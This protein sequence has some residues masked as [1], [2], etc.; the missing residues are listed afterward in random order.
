MQLSKKTNC[1]VFVEY[2]QHIRK[3]KRKQ[4]ILNKDL[5]NFWTAHCR[6]PA[7]TTRSQ[8][9]RS[10]VAQEHPDGEWGCECGC[11]FHTWNMY[12]IWDP[13]VERTWAT[14]GGNGL[15]PIQY[16]FPNSTEKFWLLR[17]RGFTVQS[18]NCFR[19]NVEAAPSQRRK[20]PITISM[21]LGIPAVRSSNQGPAAWIAQALPR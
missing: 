15:A 7:P 8:N 9:L 14:A 19:T 12:N 3:S 17:P 1:N 21:P 18:S 16:M 13:M 11:G 2:V 6:P 20:A 4:H 10:R 5:L